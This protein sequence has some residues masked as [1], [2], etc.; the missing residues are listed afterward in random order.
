MDCKGATWV[1]MSN[2]IIFRSPAEQL[3]SRPRRPPTLTSIEHYSSTCPL[4]F[5]ALK[6]IEVLGC[7]PRMAYS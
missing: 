2:T 6:L 1:L 4:C 5:S 7:S 3:E